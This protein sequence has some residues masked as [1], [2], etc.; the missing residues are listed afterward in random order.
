MVYFIMKKAV[1]RCMVFLCVSYLQN[2]VLTTH[3]D[4]IVFFEIK[5]ERKYLI[6]IRCFALQF[7]E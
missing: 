5:V 1:Q 3:T 7:E 4:H 6:I 2:L